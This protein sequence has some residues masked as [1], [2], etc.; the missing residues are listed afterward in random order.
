MYPT[1]KLGVF[2][3]GQR[4]VSP[5]AGALRC[6][7]VVLLAVDMPTI[8]GSTLMPALDEVTRGDLAYLR[9]HGRNPNYLKAKSAAER[10]V[11][12]YSTSDLTSIAKRVTALAEK[13]TRVHVI[14]NN[15][16]EDFAPKTALA[17][18]QL[19]AGAIQ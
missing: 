7:E 13:A 8:P 9:L 19:L 11:Y 14:A 3:P 5:L 1:A 2:I 4:R 6:I 15:H 16:A 10:H 12:E 18:K 17:L